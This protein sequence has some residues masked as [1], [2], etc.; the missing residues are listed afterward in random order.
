M[1]RYTLEIPKEFYTLF[2]FRLEG[3]N[4]SPMITKDAT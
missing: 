2:L 4:L 3:D 1:P